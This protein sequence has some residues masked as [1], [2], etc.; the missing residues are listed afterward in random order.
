[1]PKLRFTTDTIKRLKPPTD[2]AKVQYFDS[3]LTGFMIEVVPQDTVWTIEIVEINECV[4]HHRIFRCGHADYCA[5][6][7]LEC[8]SRQYFIY[9]EWDEFAAVKRGQDFWS[10]LNRVRLVCICG[11]LRKC[12][13]LFLFILPFYSL[14]LSLLLVLFSALFF[15]LPAP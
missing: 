6:V 10:R 14:L 4:I 12:L 8:V 7:Y 1:M 11:T 9:K 3:E 13:S 2:K 5:C 15:V